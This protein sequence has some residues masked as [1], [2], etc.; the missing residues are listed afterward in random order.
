M[1]AYP[2]AADL[3]VCA[4]VRATPNAD[5]NTQQLRRCPPAPI[6]CSIGSTASS[7][8]IWSFCAT[9]N[10]KFHRPR[11]GARALGTETQPT[12]LVQA[13]LDAHVSTCALSPRLWMWRWNASV[14]SEHGDGL[15]FVGHLCATRLSSRFIFRKVEMV[16]LEHSYIHRQLSKFNPF[17]SVEVDVACDGS[18]CGRSYSARAGSLP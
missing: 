4:D 13:L 9:Q 18:P 7:S 12:P 14:V 15:R 5:P 17:L 10:G 6:L 1:L 2:P 3:P 16:V 8:S 11:R